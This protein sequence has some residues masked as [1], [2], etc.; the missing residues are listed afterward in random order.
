M[1]I[2]WPDFTQLAILA[3]IEFECVMQSACYMINEPEKKLSEYKS[4]TLRKIPNNTFHHRRI[5]K[6]K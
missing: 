3:M 5:S 6:K 1:I 2:P 4:V